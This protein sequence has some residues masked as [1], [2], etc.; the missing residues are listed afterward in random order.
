MAQ[1][2]T[3]LESPTLGYQVDSAAMNLDL[4]HSKVGNEL[5]NHWCA[6]RSK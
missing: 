1:S 3:Q 2:V 6:M 4:L 5:R